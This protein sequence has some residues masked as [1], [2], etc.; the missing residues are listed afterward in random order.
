M[1]GRAIDDDPLDHLIRREVGLADAVTR[2]LMSMLNV[3]VKAV[4]HHEDDLHPLA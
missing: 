4:V 1:V 2:T 3:P